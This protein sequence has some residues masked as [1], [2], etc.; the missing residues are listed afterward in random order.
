MVENGLGITLL[1]TLAAG[2]LRGTNLVSRPLLAD[3]PA[4]KIG[5]VWRNGTRRRNEFRLLADELAR[6]AKPLA[7]EVDD[8]RI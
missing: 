2:L 1:P 6:Q 5:L 3:R 4:R 8:Y 7:V